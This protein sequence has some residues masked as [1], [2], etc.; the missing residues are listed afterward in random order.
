M[1][2]RNK[3]SISAISSSGGFDVTKMASKIVKDLDANG[4]GSVDK[5]EFTKG[6]AAKG[7]SAD[8][9][10]KKFDSI[11][12][13]KTGKISQNNIE[14]D[15]KKNAPKGDAPKGPPPAGGAGKSGGA[16][17]SSNSTTYDVKDTNKDGKVS[18]MEELVY[19][20]KNVTKASSKTSDTSSTESAKDAA[21]QKIGSIVD[22]TV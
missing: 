14:T 11:D 16:S 18:A 2:R 12:T 19:E 6:M 3:M 13:K 17:Q 1:F 7:M 8:E 15:L 5:A 22:V 9:A 20:M 21:K 4:D 10:A